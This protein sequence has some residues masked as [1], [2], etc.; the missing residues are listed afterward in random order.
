MSYGAVMTIRAGWRR[1][2]RGVGNE[3]AV[4]ADLAGTHVLLKSARRTARRQ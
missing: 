4:D 2:R 3:L 1:R